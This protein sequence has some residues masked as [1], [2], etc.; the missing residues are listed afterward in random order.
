MVPTLAGRVGQ[1]LSNPKIFFAP[2][3]H[4]PHSGVAQG[5]S[6]DELGAQIQ[7]LVK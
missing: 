2:P 4:I 6:L 5:F 7:K 1:R 3:F